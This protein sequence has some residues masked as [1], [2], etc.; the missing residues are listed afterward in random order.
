ME[1]LVISTDLDCRY[2]PKGFSLQ[3]IKSEYALTAR[4]HTGEKY[5]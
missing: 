1:W 4:N 2:R 3:T 5:R